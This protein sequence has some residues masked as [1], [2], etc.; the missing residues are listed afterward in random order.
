MI[1]QDNEFFFATRRTG[2]AISVLKEFMS[3]LVFA[4]TPFSAFANMYNHKHCR[5][6]EQVVLCF[7]MIFL[8]TFSFCTISTAAR[9]PTIN[10]KASPSCCTKELKPRFLCGGFPRNSNS[11]KTRYLFSAFVL[12]VPQSSVH[13][14]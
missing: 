1:A 9:C 5:T 3:S 14:Y 4:K 12:S 10:S 13:L 7:F 2:F 8:K 11:F 6:P